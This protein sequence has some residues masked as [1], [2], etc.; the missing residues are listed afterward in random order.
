MICSSLL[1]FLLFPSY[2]F[3]TI[4][5]NIILDMRAISSMCIWAEERFSLS[6]LAEEIGYS[7]VDDEGEGGGGRE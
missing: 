6:P 7:P 2:I 4:L 5:F 1:F 3:C